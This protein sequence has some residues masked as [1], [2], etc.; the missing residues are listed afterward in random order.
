MSEVVKITGIPSGDPHPVPQDEFVCLDRYIVLIDNGNYYAATR[1]GMIEIDY[2]T[3][4][5]LKSSFGHLDIDDINGYTYSV[6]QREIQLD[7]NATTGY[8]ASVF[9]IVSFTIDKS[10]YDAACLALL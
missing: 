3:Y 4:S 9:G 7:W 5:S 6:S 10:A 2:T 1:T 8:S